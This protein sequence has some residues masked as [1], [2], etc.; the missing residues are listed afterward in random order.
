[1]SNVSAIS[2]VVFLLVSTL[3]SRVEKE[4][5]F[6]VID[7]CQQWEKHRPI[8]EQYFSI[9]TNKVCCV[10]P[11]YSHEGK[12]SLASVH[13]FNG[14]IDLNPPDKLE[15][16]YAELLNSG[17]RFSSEM[18]F[19]EWGALNLAE[20]DVYILLPDDFCSTKRFIYDVVF[21]VYRAKLRTESYY[22][23]QD[24]LPPEGDPMRF[25]PKDTIRRNRTSDN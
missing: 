14:D 16:I 18:S 19:E 11:F 21:T 10:P 9:T 20:K 7:D 2:A 3:F 23:H 24:L 1:M 15:I 13:L 5:V 4:K 6:V 25:F 22:T 8:D 12:D 17:V